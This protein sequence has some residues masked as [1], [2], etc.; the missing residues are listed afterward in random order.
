MSMT[1]KTRLQVVT[2]LTTLLAFAVALLVP[3]MARAEP[4]PPPTSAPPPPPPTP[5]PPHSTPPS[6]TATPPSATPAPEDPVMVQAKQHFESG[7]NAYNAG[8]YAT[9]IKEFKAAEQLRPSPILAYNIGLANEK[10]GRKRVAV[11]YYR[12]YLELQPNAKN[13]DEVEQRI[14]G[15]EAQI[16]QEPAAATAQPGGTA[17]QPNAEVEQP[18]D[19][20]PA[21]GTVQP[22]PTPGYDPYASP[23]PPGYAVQPKKKKSYWWIGLIIG[24]AVTITVVVAV[25]AWYYTAN[26]ITTVPASATV[27]ATLPRVDRHDVGPT[28]FRF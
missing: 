21:Q 22:A 3:E 28:L 5:P 9:A 17:P 23:P 8:D 11:R 14:N 4:P 12:H 26:A 15:L 25:V 7:R 24:G 27:P 10:Q 2:A 20:P 1:K 19:M 6:A 16:A 18:S 13:R